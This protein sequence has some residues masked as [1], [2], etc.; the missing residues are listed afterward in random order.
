M[1]D[2]D[3]PAFVGL[4]SLQFSG[5]RTGAF[6][7]AC[8]F[9]VA[10]KDATVLGRTGW[11]CSIYFLDLVVVGGAGDGMLCVCS[12]MHFA[13]GVLVV[14]G[15]VFVAFAWPEQSSAL[16]EK[17]G[18]QD[19]VPDPNTG[20]FHDELALEEW[21][22]ENIA[23]RQASKEDSQDDASS[24]ASSEFFKGG[25]SGRFNDNKES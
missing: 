14:I 24:L 6:F 8:L 11:R 25:C 7:N 22:E 19:D 13:V 21:D 3:D 10:G 1:L 17:Q 12:S 15:D 9:G 2:R 23:D 4:R 16:F 18:A 5:R 20:V